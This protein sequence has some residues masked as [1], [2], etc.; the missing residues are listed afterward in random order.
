MK[1]LQSLDIFRGIT[2][3]GMILVNNP[4]D[5]GHIYAPLR[6][7]EWHGCTP[8]DLVFPFF[9]FIVGVSI[10]YALQNAEKSQ[11]PQL[12]RKIAIRSFKLFAL[13]LL[14]TAFPYFVFT[15]EFGLHPSLLNIRI[16][17]VLQRIAIC[18][19]LVSVWFIYFK[20]RYFEIILASILV[21]YWLLMRFVPLPD[22]GISDWND[23]V[24]NLAA[25]L[26]RLILG[27]NHLWKGAKNLWDPEGLL[28]TLPALGTVLIGIRTGMILKN[29]EE[30][31]TDKLLKIM[32]LGS[33]LVVAGYVTDWFFPINKSIWTSSYVLFTGGLAMIGLAL[34]Y[35]FTD[36]LGHYA[37]AFP[38][39][40]FGMNAIV[41]FAM[42]GIFS[43]VLGMFEIQKT[44]FIAF[45]NFLD[46]KSASLLFAFLYIL[47]WYG[48]VLLMYKRN[49][50][51]KI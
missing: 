18:Y 15:P 40:V 25:W 8:T 5:W 12:I 21:L 35:Y 36:R 30:S 20:D 6:H 51:V 47:F 26:D 22:G 4:A 39:K 10:T 13:G 17:G 11:N 19:L 27:E 9:L 16:L 50:F 49:I 2:I 29:K 45:Q 1:R 43:R 44:L 34:C 28:S 37:W 46:P 42:S 38:F 41:A 48:I 33:L 31:E 14:M 32:V 3:A 7:A 24:Q 23:P